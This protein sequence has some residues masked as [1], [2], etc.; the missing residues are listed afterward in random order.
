VA[1]GLSTLAFLTFGVVV[2]LVESAGASVTP[3]STVNELVSLTGSP[4]NASCPA[5]ISPTVGSYTNL[6]AAIS[7]ASPGDAIYVCAGEYDLSDTTTY[8]SSEEVVVNKSVTIDGANWNAPYATSDTA[9]SVSSSSQSV[10]ENGVGILVQAPNVTIQ[11]FTF[12]ANNFNNGTPDCVAAGTSYACS[13]SIDVQSNV[14]TPTPGNQGEN[15]VTIDD[16]LLVNTGGGNFQNGDVHFGLGQSGPG[17]DVTLLNTGDVVEG[18]VFY[19]GSGFENSALEI[20]D[21]TGI[22]VE[23]NTVNYPDDPDTNGFWFA[24]FDQATQVESNTLNAG[25]GAGIDATDPQ[26]G[27]KF[28]DEDPLG[29]YGDGCSGQLISGN[30]VSGFAY[31]ISIISEGYDADAQA[32]CQK[33]PS[34]FT[35]TGNTVSNARVY[36]IYLSGSTGGSIYNNNASNTDAEGYGPANYTPGEYDYYDAWGVLTPNDWTAGSNSGTGYAYPSSI[37]E[38]PPGSPTTMPP[39]TSTLPTATTMA[40][41]PPSTLLAKPSVTTSG[42]KLKAGNKVSVTVHCATATCSGTLQLTKTVTTKV[43]IGSTKKYR[44]KSTVEILG[45]TRYSVAAG[46]KRAFS[47]KLN[48]NGVKHLRAAKERRYTCELAITSAAG[49]TRRALS[50]ARSSA[51][52]G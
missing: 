16:N 20:S 45:R 38:V 43:E 31:D 7:A 18:N 26:T 11:G 35:V 13:S 37:G 9:A 30:I 32:L 27:M 49:T 5:G 46:A 24:G 21:T 36:G 42:V 2:G 39:T 12:D 47:V 17:T 22:V 28:N 6:P 33:G 25:L 14:G 48:A 40:T 10:I 41:V 1:L 34:D 3:P 51:T 8:T 44:T 23:S 50:F 15:N 52:S 29:Q 4:A 19:Q